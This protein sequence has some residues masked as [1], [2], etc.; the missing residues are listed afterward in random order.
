MKKILFFTSVLFALLAC[1][2]D[3]SISDPNNRDV[4]NAAYKT[5]NKSLP[6]HDTVHI[7]NSGFIPVNLKIIVG[8]TVKWINED[9]TVHT[10][11]AEKF[12][13]GD[14]PAGG[15]FNYTFNS[16]GTYNYYCKYHP[17]KGAVVVTGGDN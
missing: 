13:S 10:V 16:S 6:A 5:G 15:T 14:I 9:N 4:A 8:N 11:T 2:K 7:L 17:E 3:K 12:D 1:S